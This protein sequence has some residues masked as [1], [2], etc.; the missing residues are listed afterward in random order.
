MKALP[1]ILLNVVVWVVIIACAIW[2]AINVA[3]HMAIAFGLLFGVLLGPTRVAAVDF[4]Q[5]FRDPGEPLQ[6]DDDSPYGLVRRVFNGAFPPSL[7]AAAIGSLWF[8][9]SAG[10]LGFHSLHG[11]KF[12]GEMI[13]SIVP[14]Q[15]AAELIWRF[16]LA[17]LPFPVRPA[18]FLAHDRVPA[19]R[20][21]Q[22]PKTNRRRLIVCADGT[23]NWPDGVLETNVI[24]LVRAI[25]PVDGNGISQLVHYHLGVGTGNILDRIAG[26]GAG[27]GLSLSVKS[28]YGFIVD[29]YVEGDEIFLFGF[30]RGAFVARSVAGMIG[31]VGLL[32]KADMEKFIHVWDWYAQAKEDRKEE[33]L[34]ALAPDRHEQVDIQCVGVWDTVGALGIPGSRFCLKSFAFYETELGIHVRH[35][36]QALAIDEQRGNFQSAI[37]VPPRAQ[38]QNA[39]QRAG[40]RPAAGAVAA[41]VLEQAWF[42]GVHSN[43]GGGYARHGL[44]DTA[45]LWMLAQLQSRH[46]L[47]LDADYIAA[48][49]DPLE[50]Y[51]TGSLVNSRTIFWRLIG[52]P[53]PRPVCIINS[54]ERVHE[55]AQSRGTLQTPPLQRA[56]IYLRARRKRWLAA[57]KDAV[58]ARLPEEKVSAAAGAS[59]VVANRIPVPKNTGICGLLLKVVGGNG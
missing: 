50:S 45:H 19:V 15:A 37:W 54:T 10:I 48:A 39:Q 20:A 34:A 13:I 24:R 21:W 7:L 12:V 18:R 47:G 28:C 42:P 43:V 59:T 4:R 35:A 40:A 51:P 53:V 6:A 31:T 17:V 52:S 22:A 32:R 5:W 3:T 1:S 8:A 14:V 56:D 46:L 27:V 33:D 26:G 41:Q 38:A 30:S 11:W 23:W 36:F 58:I 2:S 29:N 16:G 25:T 57:V 49:L 9:H 44:S 55:S